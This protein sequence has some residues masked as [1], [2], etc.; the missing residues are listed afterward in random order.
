MK[1]I[2]RYALI[3][4]TAIVLPLSDA[5][6]R[7]VAGGQECVEIAVTLHNEANPGRDLWDGWGTS[8]CWWANRIGYNDRLTEQAASLFFDKTAGL[9][10]NIMRYNIGGG[11]AP[12]HHHITRT[13]SDIPGWQ[14]YDAATGTCT[15]DYDADARQLAVLKAADKAAGD[16]AIVEVFSNSPP[17]F[18]TVSGCSSGNFRASVNNLKPDRYTDFAQY[19]A[20]VTDHIVNTL[21]IKVTSVSPMNEPNTD[22]WSAFSAKQEGCHFDAGNPQNTIVTETRKALDGYG[23]QDVIVAMSDETNP[24]KQIEE[25]QKLSPEARQAVGRINAHTYGTNGIV[26]LGQLT[27]QENLSLWMSEVDGNG[28]SG[29]NAGEMASGL[30]LADK[31][32][33]DIEALKPSA[34]VLWQVIDTHVSK[35]GFKGRRDNGPLNRNRGFWGLAWADHDD[36]TIQLTQK[37]YAFGQFTRYIRP[38]ARII[39]CPLQPE[40]GLRSIAAVN[41]DGSMAVVVVNLSGDDKDVCIDL[42]DMMTT[43]RCKAAVVRTSGDIAMGEHWNDA[44]TVRARHGRIQISSAANSISTIVV[45]KGQFRA[46]D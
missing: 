2:R 30:W 36:S 23:L 20:H 21:N 10:L 4:L 17:Y 9:G 5:I 31:I 46:A 45:S 16:E 8:L 13:D 1:T 42:S 25:I 18:M 12:S 44:G 32:I 3:A 40:T 7:D 41:S 22:Y 38:G 24:G 29:S 6:C 43:T 37:Y 33:S 14:K 34:W 11:D 35:D 28:T 39:L 19:L 26:S 15:Y 27:H